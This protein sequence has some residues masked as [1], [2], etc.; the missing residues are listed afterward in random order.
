[1]SAVL[2]QNLA[3]AGVAGAQQQLGCLP[4]LSGVPT[5]VRCVSG[6]RLASAKSGGRRTARPAAGVVT[7]AAAV[8]LNLPTDASP[9]SGKYD[10][11][12]VGGGTAGCVLANKLTEDGSKRV[13]VLEAGAENKDFEVKAPAGITRLFKSKLDWNMY[14]Q[15]QQQL[16]SRQVYIARGKLLGGSSATNATLYHRGSYDDY[17]SWG[18]PGWGPEDV[19]PWYKKCEDNPDCGSTRY[20]AMGGTMHVE[21]P[22][23]N[24]KL[25]DVFFQASQ[26]AGVPYNPDFNDWSRNQYGYGEFQVTQDKGRRADMFRQYLE[27]VLGRS[28]LQVQTLCKVTKLMFESSS[29]GPVARGVQFT[30]RGPDGKRH[31][32]ELAAG[33]EVIL[34]A[35]SVHTPHVLMLSGLGPAA[36][37]RQYGIEPVADLPGVGANFQDHPACV[38]A[39]KLQERH[40]GLSITNQIYKDGAKIRL[41]AVADWLLRGRGPLATTGCDHGAFLRSTGSGQPD[42][43]LR[44]VPAMAIDPDGVSSY[45]EFARLQASGVVTKWPAG[46][47]MQIVGCRPRSRGHISLRT[48]DPFDQPAINP[49][50]LT[51]ADGKDAAALRWGIRFTRQLAETPAFKEY[52]ESEYWPG[53]DLQ[54][55][56]ALDS[57]IRSTLH[58]ANAIVGTCAMGTD[59]AK[60]AVV[61]PELKVH[62]VQGLRVIDASVIPQ[63]IGGQTGAPT[64]MVA[65]RG[66]ALLM[67]QERVGGA[68]GASAP[69]Q[70]VA[71]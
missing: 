52:L 42:V 48:D 5:K 27:P 30:Q 17:Q 14:S 51:D 43:Q 62:G 69:P 61:T 53:Q 47:T 70:P 40:A 37:L 55:D 16:D 6:T 21:N 4:R 18:V 68:S 26:E 71:A 44:F 32:A 1:M 36:T 10:Y 15:L 31:I 20:H 34:T 28:N 2:C 38:T 64:V 67:G 13:L 35:G 63:I 24:N 7:H 23:Y 56:D 8:P 3:P 59:P 45:V 12:L 29:S 11:I 33:G 19:L 39:H 54:D 65:E 57:F 50:Y 60:G 22:R 46:I 66:A 25:H 49:G 9:V 41:T 58:S